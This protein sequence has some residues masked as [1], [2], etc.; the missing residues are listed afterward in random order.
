MKIGILI[1]SAA[2]M[3]AF[4]AGIVSGARSMADEQAERDYYCDQVAL[5]HSQVD[6]GVPR[7][8]ALGWPPFNGECHAT[9]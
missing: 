8:Y 6:S 2:A 3:F 7:E 9:E 5:W 4:I 1:A